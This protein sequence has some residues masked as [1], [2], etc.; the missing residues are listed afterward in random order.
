MRFGNREYRIT[1]II[2]S[3]VSALPILMHIING[4]NSRMLS[5]DYCFAAKVQGKGLT[6]T[7]NYYYYNWTGTFSST[8]VQSVIA[9]TG[10]GLVQWLPLILIICWWLSLIYL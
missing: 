9:F 7:M 1:L 4:M 6:Y 2:I 10:I 5:D 3:V 8:A